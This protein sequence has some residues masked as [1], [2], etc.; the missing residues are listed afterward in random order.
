[1]V[2]LPETKQ[3]VVVLINANTELPLDG[4]NATMSR[5]PIGIVSLLNGYPPPRGKSLRTAYAVTNFAAA[6]TLAVVAVLAG[7]QLRARRAAGSAVMAIGAAGIVAAATT[8][9]LA[10]SLLWIFAP[11]LAVILGAGVLLLCLPLARRCLWRR[12][13][14][15]AG[16]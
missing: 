12:H 13:P 1:M 5:L 10:P 11:E 9:G 6:A 7:F 14:K 3:A 8:A 15:H 2:L 16:D 4:L